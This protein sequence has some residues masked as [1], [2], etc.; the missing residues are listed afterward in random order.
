V[1][2]NLFHTNKTDATLYDNWTFS[3]VHVMDKFYFD[4]YTSAILSTPGLIIG[5][6]SL[7]QTYL[8]LKFIRLIQDHFTP[9]KKIFG[10]SITFINKI[11][12]TIKFEKPYINVDEE[13]YIQVA[14][15]YNPRERNM[16]WLM[17]PDW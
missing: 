2:L 13:G 1:W 3:T 12:K 17:Q 6:S 11:T 10:I 14:T 4:A 16:K 15:K 7:M 5:N 8:N 9:E